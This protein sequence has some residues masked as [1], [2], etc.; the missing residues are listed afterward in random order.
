MKKELKEKWEDFVILFVTILLDSLLV[1]FVGVAIYSVKY[2]L[3]NWIFKEKIEDLGN[4]AFVTI[5]SI[6]KI[7]LVIAFFLYISWDIISQI[8][9]IWK[10]LKK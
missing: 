2:T 5:Y 7:F 4:Q 3:E 8:I 9:K 6:S 10:R 1:L